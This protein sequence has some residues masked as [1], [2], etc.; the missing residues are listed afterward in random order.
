MS[1]KQDDEWIVVD[2]K[3]G[4][5]TY[6]NKV[7]N[8]TYRTYNIILKCH[9]TYTISSKIISLIYRIIFIHSC[10]NPYVPITYHSIVNI[11][12]LI[13]FMSILSSTITS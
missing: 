7:K 12:T 4:N 3:E 13:V 10:V 8:F 11:V 6:I 2:K 5:E 1:I 9:K